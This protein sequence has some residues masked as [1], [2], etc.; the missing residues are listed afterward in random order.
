MLEP[1]YEHDCEACK[2]VGTTDVRGGLVD[3]YRCGATVVIRLSSDGPDYRAVINYQT[4][5]G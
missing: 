5:E 4:L 2:Y 1:R 3:V